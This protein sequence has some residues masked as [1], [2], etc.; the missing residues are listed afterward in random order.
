MMWRR[1]LRL[2]LG[3]LAVSGVWLHLSHTPSAGDE[4]AD[5][6]HFL[7]Q[8]D[9]PTTRAY[10]LGSIHMLRQDVYPLASVIEETFAASDVLVLEADVFAAPQ[11]ELVQSIMAYAAY[12]PGQT[13][14]SELPEQDYME[15]LGI[16]LEAGIP[17]DSVQQYQPWYVSLMVD[18]VVAGRLGLRPEYGIDAYFRSKA[19]GQ[20]EI[21]EL[22]SFE[23]Q[24]ELL[25]GFSDQEQ[26][27]MMSWAV[28]DL[29]HAAEEFDE[30]L[31]IWNRGDVQAM[32]EQMQKEVREDPRFE[33]IWSVMVDERN[34]TM[35]DRIVTFMGTNK[36]H[37]IIVGA[38]HLV[39]P[40]GLIA[41]LRQR[42]YNV[43]QL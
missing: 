23:A 27:L 15:L 5:S 42:G 10:L 33:P 16:L 41:V 21:Q 13:L 30:M 40:R 24:L 9:S 20:K 43:Q 29:E 4:R 11:E 17:S 3:L 14:K 36:R 2:I 37:F 6:K 38:A 32:E 25:A 22:E 7:W 1:N 31:H 35:V 18:Q 26:V 39:G 12:P 34:L 19:S 28:E 8:V